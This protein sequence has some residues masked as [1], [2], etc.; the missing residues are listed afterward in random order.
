MSLTR[1]LGHPQ[2]I[3]GE[4]WRLSGITGDGHVT[5]ISNCPGIK[6][7]ELLPGAG[8]ISLCERSFQ[9]EDGRRLNSQL[10][11]LSKF[12]APSGSPTTS[13]NSV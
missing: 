7:A 9:E 2:R 10:T 11:S 13:V 5:C 1:R 4:V 3:G 12:L 8:A 6:A